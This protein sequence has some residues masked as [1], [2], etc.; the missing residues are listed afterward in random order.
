MQ[1]IRK[2]SFAAEQLAKRQ[3]KSPILLILVVI[4][5]F[6]VIIGGAYV[7]KTRFMA[8]ETPE[9]EIKSIAVL[10]L[11]NMS[12]DPEQLYFTDGMHEA[13]INDSVDLLTIL[14]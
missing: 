1:S 14:T 11:D 10:P 3:K 13:L 4:L 7:I 5:G 12:G 9:T 2:K 6:T 8:V